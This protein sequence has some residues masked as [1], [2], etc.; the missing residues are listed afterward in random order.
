MGRCWLKCLQLCPEIDFNVS[1]LY[2]ESFVNIGIDNEKCFVC[3]DVKLI[4]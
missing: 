4:L 3:F 1:Y 2:V